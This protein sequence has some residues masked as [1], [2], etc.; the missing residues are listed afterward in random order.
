MFVIV[1]AH[2]LTEANIQPNVYKKPTRYGGDME[3]TRK[4]RLNH[5]ILNC[6]L[7]FES[8]WLSNGF[9]TPFTK[10]NI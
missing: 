8:S 3:R 7:D 4:S 9:C 1:S 10:A 6:D 2:R 5:M